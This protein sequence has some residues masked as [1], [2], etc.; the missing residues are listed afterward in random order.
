MLL[1]KNLPC[2]S[3]KSSYHTVNAPLD[4]RGGDGV[5][6]SDSREL[7]LGRLLRGTTVVDYSTIKVVRRDQS[8][9]TALVEEVEGSSSS[10]SSSREDVS[11]GDDSVSLYGDGD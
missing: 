6:G 7:T 11:V 8:H 9:F 10:N 4:L 1:L 2:C 3:S 5:G